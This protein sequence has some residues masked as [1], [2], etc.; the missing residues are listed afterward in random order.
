MIDLHVH[1]LG[2][3]DREA[4]EENIR[5]FLNQAKRKNIRQIGFADHDIYLEKSQPDLI[6]K[7]AEEYPDLQVRVGIE[8]DYQKDRESQ[9][10]RMISEYP[11]DFIIGSVHQIG[12]WLFDYPGEEKKHLEWDAD[13][14]Y[15]TYFEIVEN[16][17]ASKIFNII[18]HLDLIKIFGV[19]PKTDV[20][21]LAARALEA[22]KD[23]RLAVEINTNGLYKPVQEF[24]PE[25]KLIEQ[26]I[27]MEIPFTLGSDAHEA[28]AAGRDIRE[29]CKLLK[30][31][32]VN[33]VSGFSRKNRE[34]F[35]L[36]D[37]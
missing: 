12:N 4:T 6:R 21:I 16:A 10:V 28:A 36:E 30:T 5:D 29:A 18:G 31:L 11:F 23:C 20:R 8:A 19:R 15:R 2:H 9:I 14:L 25:A 34:I 26:I 7:V 22:I 24:Y 33:E 17:A 3:L 32:G 27:K 1:L 35:C 37:V 13:D